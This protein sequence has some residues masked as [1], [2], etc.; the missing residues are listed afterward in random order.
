MELEGKV[1]LITGAARGIGLQIATSFAQEG[2]T[3]FL[4]DINKDNL[5][6]AYIEINKINPKVYKYSCDVTN[7]RKVGKM[8]DWV[9]SREEKLDIL[10]NN[11]GITLDCFFHKM[12]ESNW[13]KV[14]KINLYGT[15]N[16]TRAAI[17]KM[18]DNG[19]G[20]IISISSVVAVAG[21]IG[22]VNYAA[23][24]AAII[25][26]TKSLALESASK[27]ITVNAIAPG[28]IQS[29]MTEVIPDKIK[30]K[31]ISKIPIGR[32]GKTIDVAELAL[33]LASDKSGYITGQVI[34][35]N[36]GYYL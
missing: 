18:R 36:G 4:N 16:C 5:N 1:S 35:V 24:K 22:Q 12:E 9:F 30:Q 20:R 29:E 33:F 25:G 15:Y 34:S 31:I 8:F 11:A 21:N 13:D 27:N 10:V 14:I 19:Y 17:L 2:S 28:F 32:F 6:A 26:L 23:S 3:V 7:A